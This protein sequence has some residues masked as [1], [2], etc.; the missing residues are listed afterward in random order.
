MKIERETIKYEIG[1]FMILMKYYIAKKEDD[2]SY[3]E[4]HPQQRKIYVYIY[5]Y[6]NED[7]Q[8]DNQIWDWQFHDIN[9][10]LYRQTKK[11]IAHCMRYI[12]FRIKDINI[13][14][15]RERETIKSEI[16]NFTIPMKYFIAKE[17]R[18][19]FASW[20]TSKSHWW[21]IYIE[22]EREGET[23]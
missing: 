1:N 14:E 11:T 10:I 23:I 5:I 9:E 16:D 15:K 2:I 6:I 17:K 22:E 7:W 4:I 13:N 20:D 8:R 21:Y 19:Y 12:K 18:R 3:H